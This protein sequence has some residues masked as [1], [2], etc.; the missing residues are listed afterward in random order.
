MMSLVDCVLQCRSVTVGLDIV[1]WTNW[2]VQWSLLVVFGTA[3]VAKFPLVQHRSNSLDLLITSPV[4]LQSHWLC[5]YS[6]HWQIQLTSTLCS[7]HSSCP[8]TGCTHWLLC[9]N[10]FKSFSRCTCSHLSGY[11]HHLFL[12]L[13]VVSSGWFFSTCLW[14][15]H[16][17]S[18]EVHWLPNV[19]LWF[20]SGMYAPRCFYPALPVLWLLKVAVIFDSGTVSPILYI[21]APPT[22]NP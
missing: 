6:V 16:G 7:V 20:S 2:Y 21:V 8:I 5:S 10:P 11:A 22:T 14:T 3:T 13:L 9:G 18:S 19:K 12:S 15:L 17:I 4:L 1:R